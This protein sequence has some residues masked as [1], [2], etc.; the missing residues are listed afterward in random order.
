MKEENKIEKG[1]VIWRDNRNFIGYLM[2]VILIIVFLFASLID[3]GSFGSWGALVVA[4]F[5]FL[6]FIFSLLKKTSSMKINGLWT[7]N[8]AHG[9]LL[10]SIFSLKQK[11][12]FLEWKD[13]QNVKIVNKMIA[14]TYIMNSA[15][16][17]VITSKDKEE[18][19]CAITDIQGFITALKKVGRY[20]LLSKDSKYR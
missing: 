7:G 6:A 12:I 15:Q 10:T 13:I 8:I 9:E 1:E 14:V 16:F 20:N 17:I 19:E 4:I 18:Y 2:I 11:N 5:L 3:I